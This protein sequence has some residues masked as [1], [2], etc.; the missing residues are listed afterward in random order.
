MCQKCETLEQNLYDYLHE[1]ELLTDEM[2]EV[3]KMFF[4]LLRLIED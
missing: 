4:N 2:K 3:L 1:K